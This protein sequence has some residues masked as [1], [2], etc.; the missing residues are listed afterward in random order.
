M[1][2]LLFVDV[3]GVLNVG[4]RDDGNAPLAFTEENL[5][6]A[7]ELERRPNLLGE[8]LRNVA[9]R[10][11]GGGEDGT[12]EKLVAAPGDLSD[13]L[14]GRLARII[15]AAG[16]DCKVVLSSS[17]RKPRYNGR[18]QRL[19][20]AI[21]RQLGRSSFSFDDRTSLRTENTAE[22]RLECLGDYISEFCKKHGASYDKLRILVL[23][24][25][26]INELRGLCCRG[27]P[28]DSP[29]D[30]ETYLLGQAGN[31]SK[32]AIR[33]I[34]TYEGW[35]TESG[36][37]IAIGCG[38]TTEHYNEALLFLQST[39]DM[40]PVGDGTMSK[41]Q[42]P[43]IWPFALHKPVASSLVPSA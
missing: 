43:W 28:V 36:T 27:H 9:S 26:C 19:E 16:S 30:A 35:V 39:S 13:L 41:Q 12:F 17:W 23:E 37:I 32:V 31:S 18:T 20:N 5:K 34:H 4:I 14:V 3:D 6:L 21:A 33:V 40:V 24:D 10:E 42:V 38:L 2:T 8:K 7:R 11:L 1:R 15:Q 22:D 25:F 29:A